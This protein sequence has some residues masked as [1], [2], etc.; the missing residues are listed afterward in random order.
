MNLGPLFLSSFYKGLKLWIDQ[1]EAKQ[2][3]PIA[4]LMWFLFL[5]VNEYFPELYRDCGLMATLVQD[6]ST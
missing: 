4:G 6:A 1:L 2:N 5:W 3:K